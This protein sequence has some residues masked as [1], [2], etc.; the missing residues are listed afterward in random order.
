MINPIT[1]NVD[2]KLSL[3]KY[4]VD[5][6]SLLSLA[7]RGFID[8]T[9]QAS[10]ASTMRAVS[11]V[12][13]AVFSARRRFSRSGISQAPPKGWNTAGDK[14][15]GRAG[16][17]FCGRSGLLPSVHPSPRVDVMEDCARTRHMR[18][19]AGERAK[20]HGAC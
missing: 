1:V 16:R 20:E 13:H 6:E 18:I 10:P 12:G 7:P 8:A 3:N 4:D 14:L 9:R 17:R 11:N 2:A 19:S 15:L 5:E